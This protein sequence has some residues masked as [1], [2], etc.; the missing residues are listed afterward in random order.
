MEALGGR[1]IRQRIDRLQIKL[2][3]LRKIA[4]IMTPMESEIG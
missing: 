2:E 4:T 3:W 1:K